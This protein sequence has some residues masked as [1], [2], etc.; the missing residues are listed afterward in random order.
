VIF[1]CVSPN[2]SGN[3][4]GLWEFNLSTNTG[5]CLFNMQHKPIDPIMTVVDNRIFF[6]FFH[7]NHCIYDLSADKGE[8]F[9]SITNASAQNYVKVKTR[10]AN[11]IVYDR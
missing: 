3:V 6:S 8:V 11:G 9:F 4:N 10:P 2:N 1:S 5:K 7:D